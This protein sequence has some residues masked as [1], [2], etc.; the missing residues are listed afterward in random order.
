M[1]DFISTHPAAD[2]QTVACARLLAAV[3]A[4]AIDDA[5]NKHAASAD[6]L[7]AIDWLFDTTS[8]F[9]KYAALIGAD[10]AAIRT[11]LLAPPPQV[12]PINSKFDSSRRRYIRIAHAKWLTRR[13]A[14]QKL[15][16]ELS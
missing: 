2:N 1:I 4:Q 3:I 15:L 6:Q 14:A 8:P 10:A 7:A 9:T 5:S 12:E 11:A 13:E 16:R